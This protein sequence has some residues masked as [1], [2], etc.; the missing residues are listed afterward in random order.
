M[1]KF[2][3]KMILVENL[4]KLDSKIRPR[5]LRENA[6]VDHKIL[7]SGEK[8]PARL[9]SFA[10]FNILQKEKCSSVC[11]LLSPELVKSACVTN[12]WLPVKMCIWDRQFTY[13]LRNFA[14]SLIIRT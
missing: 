10:N 4:F 2:L 5:F 8:S 11:R 12:V 14:S 6:K 9:V 7:K 3:V 1:Q 13:V